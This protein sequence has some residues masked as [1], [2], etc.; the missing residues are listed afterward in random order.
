MSE[1]R[2]KIMWEVNLTN[3]PGSMMELIPTQLE[4]LILL[5][6]SEHTEP[7]AK[8]GRGTDETI[9]GAG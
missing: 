8:P 6:L 7:A 2:F 4:T 9:V 1:I 3:G 5:I